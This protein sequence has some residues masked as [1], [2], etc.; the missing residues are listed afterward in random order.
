MQDDNY[1]LYDC[2][3]VAVCR[4]ANGCILIE[5]SGAGTIS[6]VLYC[7]KKPHLLG[8]A[9]HIPIGLILVGVGVSLQELVLNI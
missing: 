2:T 4:S 1:N 7:K 5:W 6:D 9:E 3:Y 8:G